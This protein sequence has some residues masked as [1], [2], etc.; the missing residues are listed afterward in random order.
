[1]DEKDFT[2]ILGNAQKLC[3][4][5]M[6]QSMNKMKKNA[7]KSKAEVD[8]ESFGGSVPT[9]QDASW[10]RMFL[11]EAAYTDNSPSAQRPTPGGNNLSADRPITQGTVAKSRVPDFIKQSMVNEVIDNSALS[12]NPLDRLDLTKLEKTPPQ[13]PVPRQVVTEQQQVAPVQ[14]ATAGVDYSIIRAIIKECIDEKFK[15][16]GVTKDMLTEST[17]KT[18]HLKG[19]NIKLVDNSGNVYSAQLEKKGNINDKR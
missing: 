14:V 13:M 16:L 7:P 12:A 9:G 2:R 11:S 6:N 4:M 18:I 15:E 17:L 5:D 10:D 8:P 1:M 19:G 3:S